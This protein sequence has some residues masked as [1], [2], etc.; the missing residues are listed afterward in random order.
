M[1]NGIKQLV[2]S[3]TKQTTRLLIYSST[4]LLNKQ[5][6]YSST[7]LLTIFYHSKKIRVN[8]IYPWS[9][10]KIFREFYYYH[11]LLQKALISDAKSSFSGSKTLLLALPKAVSCFCIYKH[12]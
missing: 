12:L 8:L 9:V 4:C 5:L 7:C 6:V 2:Y 10:S 1:V 11:R 3:S